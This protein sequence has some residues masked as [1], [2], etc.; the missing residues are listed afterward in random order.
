MSAGDWT[1]LC[2]RGFDSGH[3]GAG[4]VS[5]CRSRSG[6]LADVGIRGRS[7]VVALL[8]VPS[9]I[10]EAPRRVVIA[11]GKMVAAAVE[12]LEFAHRQRV[13]IVAEVCYE[14]HRRIRRPKHALAR[15][16]ADSHGAFQTAVELAHGRW[17]VAS[18]GG[19]NAKVG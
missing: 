6:I 10:R 16:S 7:L 2:G 11:A 9:K 18:S 8:L 17:S 15:N 14:L 1:V 5:A 13:T 4:G 3:D 12:T 19:P